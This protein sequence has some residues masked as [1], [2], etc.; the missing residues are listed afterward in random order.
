V[1]A[2]LLAQLGAS[3]EAFLL[4]SRLATT[5]DYPGAA[6]FWYRSMRGALADPGFPAIARQLGLIDYWK[7]SGTRPDVCT[8][9]GA[10][11]FCSLI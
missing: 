6:T 8:Q 10:P 5:Q 3:H 7:K 2:R 11:A 4:A 1:V 9:P